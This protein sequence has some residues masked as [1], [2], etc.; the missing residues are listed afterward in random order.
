MATQ[1]LLPT[2]LPRNVLTR[3]PTGS[4]PLSTPA[5]D[6]ELSEP[7]V[8]A[9]VDGD[10]IVRL[11]PDDI[12]PFRSVLDWHPSE[13]TALLA[14]AALGLRGRDEVRDAGL[15]AV[16]THESP[17]SYP[18]GLAGAVAR[19]RL[20]SGLGDTISLDEVEDNT[21]TTCGFSEIDYE[22]TRARTRGPTHRST[23]T[24]ADEAIRTFEHGAA[25]RGID[26]VTFRGIAEATNLGP[27]AAQDLRHHMIASRP[28]HYAW[29]LWSVTAPIPAATR[30]D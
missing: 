4:H 22:R 21:R 23:I 26:Y 9:L 18:V 17:N 12:G 15:V 8:L 1:R 7:D 30:I 13:A 29:P 6:G 20:A 25:R 3:A 2:L 10:P 28:D 27:A 24:G 5:L 14:A 11:S 16:L 19:N